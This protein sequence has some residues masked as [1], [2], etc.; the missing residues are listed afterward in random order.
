MK[1]ITS[2]I[3]NFWVCWKHLGMGHYNIYWVEMH[4]LL[5]SEHSY[6]IDPKYTKKKPRLCPWWMCDHQMSELVSSYGLCSSPK[7][8]GVFREMGILLTWCE[9]EIPLDTTVGCDQRSLSQKNSLICCTAIYTG[10]LGRPDITDIICNIGKCCHTSLNLNEGWDESCSSMNQQHCNS[11][12][13]T[14]VEKSLS[15]QVRISQIHILP[16]KSLSPYTTHSKINRDWYWADWGPR[17]AIVCVEHLLWGLLSCQGL[18]QEV[19]SIVCCGNSLTLSS[20]VWLA[21][22]TGY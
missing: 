14:A 12:G 1:V 21:T 3:F 6:C 15:L 13:F 9:S 18:L 8:N 5:L 4:Y 7:V 22:A 10:P 16:I 2:I 20:V 11:V 17:A 19:N